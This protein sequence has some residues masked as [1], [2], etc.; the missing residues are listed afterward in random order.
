MNRNSIASLGALLLGGYV[1]YKVYGAVSATTE[2]R[3]NRVAQTQFLHDV[4]GIYNL[5]GLD[6]ALLIPSGEEIVA[7]REPG[8]A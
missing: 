8:K 7:G 1:A 5:G 4:S 3:K 6:G 2:R